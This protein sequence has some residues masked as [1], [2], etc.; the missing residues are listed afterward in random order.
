MMP[1]GWEA[2]HEI[3]SAFAQEP[4]AIGVA[5]IRGEGM[6]AISGRRIGAYDV[7]EKLGEGGMSTVFRAIQQPLG[8]DVALKV[9]EPQNHLPDYQQRF[10]HEAQTVAQLDHPNILP[11]YDFGTEDGLTFLTMPL[12]TGGTMRERLAQGPMAADAAWAVI[13]DV[14]SAL[15]HANRA[16]VVHRDVKPNNILV[17]R[18][19]RHLLADF[20]LARDSAPSSPQTL[21]G[22]ALGTPGYMAP[23]Q[24]NGARVDHRADIFAFGVV[25]YE[26][27]TGRRPF[28]GATSLQ[29]VMATVTEPHLPPSRVNPALPHELDDVLEMMLAKR[30]DDRPRSIREAV[31]LLAR[32]PFRSSSAPFATPPV[33]AWRATIAPPASTLVT[34]PVPPIPTPQTPVTPAFSLRTPVAPTTADTS[35][36]VS[37]LLPHL[38][39]PRL[40]GRRGYVQNSF[41]S[42]L[43]NSARTLS[44]PRWP[45][46][47]RAAGMPEY[48]NRDPATN[49]DHG[50]PV[51]QVNS[52]IEA[53]AGLFTGPHAMLEL[54]SAVEDAWQPVPVRRRL[55]GRRTTVAQLLT[56]FA[57]ALDEVRGER[58]H[59]VR[60]L[61]AGQVWVVHYSN[62]FA[63]RSHGSAASCSFLLGAYEALLRRHGLLNSW[64]VSEL[65][66]GATT[67]TG[68]CV[69]AVRSQDQSDFSALIGRP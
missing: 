26:M 33:D 15:E 36:S 5:L 44:G 55:P 34:P 48:L 37:S 65:E 7:L 12:V 14:G 61:D 62:L 59:L 2:R 24:A 41:F 16:G 13:S 38:G 40:V 10:L 8:R 45:E 47:V 49:S 9:L 54:A 23:E 43:V 29:V 50:T 53:I 25:I 68:D 51:A 35:G 28:T 22:L 27:L 21:Y 56:G 11:L 66:C 42:I 31:D 69:F 1:S 4:D 32:V 39:L 58:L 3:A 64:R 17:H 63:P 60:P 57:E 46:V 30:P 67:G 19:G 18:D 20:G 6:R 52:L